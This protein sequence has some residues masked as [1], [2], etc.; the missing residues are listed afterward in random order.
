M[1]ASIHQTA[2]C[3]AESFL[4]W[5]AFLLPISPIPLTSGCLHHW[6]T[7]EEIETQRPQ[8]SWVHITHKLGALVALT[9]RAQCQ[10]AALPCPAA[11][12]WALGSPLV[13][14]PATETVV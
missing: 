13:G 4:H 14:P 10:T 6:F 12:F 3:W 1:T 2:R 7:G 9:V 11:R 8:D 5:Q